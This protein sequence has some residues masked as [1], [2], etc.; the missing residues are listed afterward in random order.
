[1][2]SG[3]DFR[4]TIR[5]GARGTQPTLVTH[6]VIGPDPLR[7][8][9]TGARVP[10]TGGQTSVG[11]VVSKAVGSAVERNRV[12]RQLRHLMR[13]RVD[14]LPRGSRVVVRALPAAQS[15]DSATLAEHLD[16]ALVRAGAR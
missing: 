1:M 3:E 12:K 7:S 2:R 16:A 8:G 9:V 5:R 6:L 14:R 15:A 11:F 4:H 13:D 10:R